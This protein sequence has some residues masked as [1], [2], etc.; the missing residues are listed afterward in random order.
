[1]TITF[2]AQEIAKFAE[3]AKIFGAPNVDVEKVLEAFENAGKAPNEL[4]YAWGHVYVDSNKVELEVLPS[5]MRK[6]SDALTVLAPSVHKFV[7]I[8]QMLKPVFVEFAE[9][10]GNV[11]E[12]IA[13]LFKTPCIN[14][15]YDYDR[16]GKRITVA[17]CRNDVP[18]GTLLI[19][20]VI[21][22]GGEPI[23][24]DE[25][26]REIKDRKPIFV[27][28]EYSKDNELSGCAYDRALHLVRRHNR[29]ELEAIITENGW[30]TV[31][32]IAESF[33]A[34]DI[35]AEDEKTAHRI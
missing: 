30:K 32:D 16:N 9:K 18:N 6:V 20:A 12:K 5:T 19:K 24:S 1:M 23:N 10:V 11:S 17:T 13:N 8:G 21:N 22:D 14:E 26:L 31:K 2:T 3:T 34:Y 7:G 33:K 15:V 28:P 29:N 27:D 25:I 35:Y 4:Q